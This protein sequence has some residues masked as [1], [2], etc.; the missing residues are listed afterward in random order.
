VSDSG[1]AIVGVYRR[2]NA[3]H[4]LGLLEPALTR[5]WRTA[6]W[7]LDGDRA[8][9][10]EFTVGEGPGLKLPLLNRLLE[11]VGKPAGWTVLSDDDLRFVRGDVVGFVELCERGAL[12]LAQPARAP[13]TNCSH[14]ITV[15]APRSRVRRTTFVESGP[16]VAIGPAWRDHILPLP[17]SRGMGWGV[18]LDWFDLVAHG[19]R[20]GIVDA[21]VIQHLGDAGDHYDTSEIRQTLRAELAARG[22]ADWR[23]FQRTLAVWRPWRRSP[24]WQGER[25]TGE[26]P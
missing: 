19:C 21:A 16:L 5:G 10:R 13:G 24:P 17:D 6:W 14:G 12:D 3:P 2:E 23:A 15:A 18:E 1:N 7:G 4:V 22:Q 20:L 25:L 26:S 11:H 9:L 8:E